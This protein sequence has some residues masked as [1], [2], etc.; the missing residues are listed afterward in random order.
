MVAVLSADELALLAAC[1]VDPLNDVPRLVYADWLEERGEDTRSLF[2]RLQIGLERGAY[3]DP[4]CRPGNHRHKYNGCTAIDRRRAMRRLFGAN[5]RDWH[6]RAWPDADAT[7]WRIQRLKYDTAGPITLEYQGWQGNIYATWRRGFIEQ[8]R[9]PSHPSFN[10]LECLSS[11]SAGLH[12][13][14]TNGITVEWSGPGKYWYIAGLPWKLTDLELEEAAI[15]PVRQLTI[16][17]VRDVFVKKHW[18]LVL[19]W[20][21]E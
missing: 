8:V 10:S 11:V 17:D 16:R 18:P 1:R 21:W 2:I 15:G 4:L 7:R 9:L 5:V 13:T 6:K 12:V 3:C 14:V 20:K 19:A